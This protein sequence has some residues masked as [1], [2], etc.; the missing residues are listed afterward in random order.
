M[1]L[2]YIT[3][4]EVLGDRSFTS[5]NAANKCR[6]KAETFEEAHNVDM[7]SYYEGEAFAYNDARIFMDKE[8]RRLCNLFQNGALQISDFGI[9]L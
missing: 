4:L 9:H 1:S 6:A 2:K 7:K 8:L 5:N 3:A